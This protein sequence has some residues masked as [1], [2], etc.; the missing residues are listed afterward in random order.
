MLFRSKRNYHS[1]GWAPLSQKWNPSQ[2]EIHAQNH[3]PSETKVDSPALITFTSGSTGIPKAACRTH[4]FLLAQHKALAESLD[5]QEGEVDLITLPVF[6]LANLASGLTSVIAD[7]DLRYPAKANSQAIAKQCS[8]HHVTRCAAS[9]AFFAKLHQDKSLPDFS[10]IYT[11]GAPVFPSLL[12]EIQEENPNMNVVTVFGSTEAEPISHS[13][14]ADTS[15]DDQTA[16]FSGKGLLVGK[17]VRAT[18]LR[19]IPD[20]TGQAIPPMSQ[21]SFDHMELPTGEIGEIVVTGDHVLKGYLHG[22][23]NEE[24]KIQIGNT[25]WHRTGDAAWLDTSERIWLTGR[26]NAAIRRP[27]QPTIYPFGIEC[28]AMNYPNVKQ[29]ALIMFQEKV[30]LVIEGDLAPKQ[31]TQLRSQ[32]AHLPVENIQMLPHIP[33]DKRHNAKIDYPALKA[34][35]NRTA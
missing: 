3:S 34:M 20:Q 16:M 28:A 18:Q 2:S 21:H 14:W 7:T 13:L 35:M 23:G 24:S 33:V 1:S 5:Y 10:A 29:C 27:D 26:C 9:P 17:A 31:L 8:K 22:K 19:I 6:A 32:L 12:H 11:G 30:T 4:G 15:E 25:I